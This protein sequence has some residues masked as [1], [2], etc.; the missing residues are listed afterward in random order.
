M[1]KFKSFDKPL[2]SIYETALRDW[3]SKMW[4][5]FYAR[6]AIFTWFHA[7]FVNE[8]TELEE[9]KLPQDLDAIL[10]P[11]EKAKVNSD[12]EGDYTPF[13]RLPKLK[14]LPKKNKSKSGQVSQDNIVVS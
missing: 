6:G 5:D 3:L 9:A 8:M 10:S 11:R 2:V 13:R 4:T 14:K 1:I 12:E 7:Q